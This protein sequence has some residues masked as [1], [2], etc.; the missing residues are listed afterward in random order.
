[1]KKVWSPRFWCPKFEG[2]DLKVHL[3]NQTGFYSII[4]FWTNF[5]QVTVKVSHCGDS[6]LVRMSSCTITTIASETVVKSEEKLL[7][8]SL[9]FTCGKEIRCDPG[10][11]N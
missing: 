1:M 2:S 5:K 6:S 11:R 8:I 3:S 7:F 10:L 9:R 4:K